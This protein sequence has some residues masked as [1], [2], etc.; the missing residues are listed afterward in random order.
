AP[1]RLHCVRI[2]EREGDGQEPQ[3][4]P[5]DQ[6]RRMEHVRWDAGLQGRVVRQDARADR[7][8]VPLLQD[9]LQLRAH[10]RNA[11]AR[12]APPDLPRERGRTSARRERSE[13][14]SG[15]RTYGVSFW[16]RRK[17]AAG[18]GQR[19][20]LRMK[21]ES[22]CFGGGSVNAPV[23]RGSGALPP[24][25]NADTYAFAPGRNAAPQAALAARWL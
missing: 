7:P 12:R 25:G 3:P 11:P 20:R 14:H 21:E 13:E 15:R 16:T 10:A 18:S 2:A 6:R 4:R 24:V 17:T 23:G 5:S 8:L 19:G 1:V 22:P 9:V